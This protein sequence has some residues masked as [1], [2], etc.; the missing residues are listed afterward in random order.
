MDKES[1]GDLTPPPSPK[2]M[3]RPK[4]RYAAIAVSQATG[5]ES[6]LMDLK[7]TPDD[8]LFRTSVPLMFDTHAILCEL[9]SALPVRWLLP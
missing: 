6:R 9:L 7:L 5:D 2:R 3:M 8:F 1:R 4:T